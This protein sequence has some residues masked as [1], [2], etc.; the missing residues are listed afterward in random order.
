M[1]TRQGFVSNSS[2]SSFCIYGIYVEEE[3][4][5]NRNQFEKNC[6]EIGLEV[7]ESPYGS[8][9]IG[10]SYSTIKDDET[11]KSFKDSVKEKLSKLGYDP[12]QKEFE[13]GCCKQ[14]WYDG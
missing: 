9:C 1:K 5:E 11:G 13:P 14:A 12:T 6:I 2:S 3:K 10:R 7:H 8:P 4:I